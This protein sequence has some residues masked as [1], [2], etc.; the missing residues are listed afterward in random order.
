MR[1]PFT[2]LSATIVAISAICFERGIA[3]SYCKTDHFDTT[4]V[5][6][7][8]ELRDTTV[9]YGHN[10]DWRGRQDTLH[11]KIYYPDNKKDV[12]SARPLIVMIH[13]GGFVDG[14]IKSTNRKQILFAK[15]GFVVASVE[16]RLGWKQDCV[17]G[18]D[19]SMAYAI[20][21]AVQDI[22]AAI[23]YLVN[24]A[25]AYKIDTKRIFLHGESAGGIASL[26]SAFVNKKDFNMEYPGT[27]SKLG[28]LN[29]AT[30][31]LTDN[32]SIKAVIS[33]SGAVFDTSYIDAKKI[34]PVLLIHGTDDKVVPFV[35]GNAYSCSYYPKLQGS[36]AIQQRFAHL[37]ACYE[38]DYQPGGG[39]GTVYEDQDSFV[40]ARESHFY[41]RVLCKDCHQIIYKD[42]TLTQ[43][44]TVLNN[45]ITQLLPQ[46]Q[47]IFAPE[48]KANVFPNPSSKEF[49]LSLQSRSNDQIE[50]AVTDIYGRILY[51]TKGS[52]D[53][54]Y[55]F[56]KNFVAGIYFM[57]IIKGTEL[58]TIKLVKQ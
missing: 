45:L 42:E 58:K 40:N 21:R 1:T 51:N 53:Q 22:N 12:F 13:G 48:F 43:D 10:K 27:S 7:R 14:S 29:N 32:F 52:G 17:P 5:F 19:T 37:D 33:R 49:K 57:R 15:K 47:N 39:H 41:K 2:L 23:R 6:K 28:G 46:Q 3:Q 54:I 9:V 4:N 38:L 31:S 30:N 24:K 20:Y 16:Y 44:K 36:S 26:T 8:D 18:N 56:G 55:T 34:I 25:A 35:S 11:L 50:I